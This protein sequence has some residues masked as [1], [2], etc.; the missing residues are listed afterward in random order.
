M[1][2]F[3]LKD[4]VATDRITVRD[5]LCHQSGPPRHDW[6]WMPAD[7]ARAQ[8]LSAMRHMMVSFTPEELAPTKDAATPYAMDGDVRLRARLWPSG[9]VDE[10]IFHQPN[11]TFLAQR[12]ELEGG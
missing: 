6:I 5:L 10:M 2:E 9:A 8:M 7:L 11:G 3:R 12:A 1:P 4:G